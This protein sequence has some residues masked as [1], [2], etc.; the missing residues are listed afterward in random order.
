MDRGRLYEGLWIDESGQVWETYDRG[1]NVIDGKLVEGVGGGWMLH[2]EVF[3]EPV[4]LRWFAAGVDWGYSPDPGAIVVAGFDAKGRCYIVRQICRL[5]RDTDW[6]AD[7]ICLLDQEFKLSRVICDSAEPDRIKVFNDRLQK[8]G[9]GRIAKKANKAV[10]LGLDIVRGGFKKSKDALCRLYI[11]HDSLQ[12]IDQGLSKSKRP[13]SLQTEIPSY[14]FPKVE[15]GKAN[16]SKPDP[17]CDEH[18]CDALRYLLVF[19]WNKDLGPVKGAKTYKPGTFGFIHNHAKK[20][21]KGRMRD[22]D[23]Y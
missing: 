17:A 7:Q 19:A 2:S 4:H 11:L 21:L 6:W 16:K 8:R 20:L 3:E 14:V 13:Y 18:L 22:Q 12:H 15:E 10:E 1:T 23:D 5:K 9:T